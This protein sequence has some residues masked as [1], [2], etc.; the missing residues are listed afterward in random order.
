MKFDQMTP[1]IRS[2]YLCCKN[3]PVYNAMVGYECR[4]FFMAT[5]E[6]ELEI[7]GKPHML[8]K[9]DLVLLNSG[10]QYKVMF[11]LGKNRFYFIKFDCTQE[12]SDMDTD[13]P[14]APPSE[15]DPKKIISRFDFEDAPQLGDY[16]I[17]RNAN[18]M[19]AL[20]HQI[21]VE[22]REKLIGWRAVANGTLAEIL[23]ECIRTQTER[24]DTS[25]LQGVLDYLNASYTKPISNLKIASMFGYH[26]YYLSSLFLKITGKTLHRYVLSLRMERAVELL[27]T[28]TLPIAQVAQAC[29]FEYGSKFS[30]RFRKEFGTTPTRYR[31]NSQ[32]QQ[33][34]R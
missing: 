27:T 24:S 34:N 31:K 12:H 32:L 19:E 3:Y 2:I 30:A 6:G 7:Q 14:G 9:G 16:M 10:V 20:L 22:S 28:S 26:P 5:G 17:L 8:Y 33:E 13:N 1:F 11:E 21:L 23:A 4:L 15:F 25:R 29:G 18:R